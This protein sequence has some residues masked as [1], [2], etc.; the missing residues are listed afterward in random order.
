MRLNADTTPENAD[1]AKWLAEMSHHPN[2]IGT[3][4]IP[5]NLWRSVDFQ[6]FAERIYLLEHQLQDKPYPLWEAVRLGLYGQDPRNV[7]P[8]RKLRSAGT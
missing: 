7:G 6:K 3:I 4:P 1:F 2:H 8:T 5:P